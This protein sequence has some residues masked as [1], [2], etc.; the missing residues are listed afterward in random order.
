MSLK[1]IQTLYLQRNF[2]D[3]RIKII[4]QLAVCQIV[5]S[6]WNLHISDHK[7]TLF[8]RDKDDHAELWDGPRTHPEEAVNFFGVDNSLPMAD[9]PKFL[10]SCRKSLSNISL[11]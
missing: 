1:K 11:W 10:N 9:L 5:K 3:K 4:V 2:I 8:T 7:T 6:D